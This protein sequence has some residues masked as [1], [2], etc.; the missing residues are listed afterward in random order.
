ML[1]YTLINE[2]GLG[3]RFSSLST[4]LQDILDS[5]QVYQSVS[6]ACQNHH[7]LD[8]EKVLMVEQLV[9]LVI[10]GFIHVEDLAREIDEALLFNNHKLS[11]SLA[12][13]ID[14]KVFKPIKAELEKNYRPLFQLS[15]KPEPT[16]LP[17]VPPKPVELEELGLDKMRAT[18]L[19][20]K[21]ELKIS[22][23]EA[24]GVP[25]QPKTMGEL[26]K[27]DLM[28]LRSDSLSA[29]EVATPIRPSQV[30]PPAKSAPAST[31]GTQ[32]PA[33][34]PFQSTAIV[35]EIKKLEKSGA[36]LVDVLKQKESRATTTQPP[37]L[38]PE[39]SPIFKPELK[40]TGMGPVMLHKELGPEPVI[41]APSFKLGRER[42][43]WDES[44][45]FSSTP[46]PPTARIET[47]ALKPTPQ[48]PTKT[49]VIKPPKVIHYSAFQ[50]PLER[51]ATPQVPPSILQKMP[52]PPITPFS[53]HLPT[54][55]Q[56]KPVA[57]PEPRVQNFL[58]ETAHLFE[59][60]RGII[61]EEKPKG[62]LSRLFVGKPKTNLNA[63][64]LE[65]KIPLPQPPTPVPQIKTPTPTV[66]GTNFM[67]PP[68]SNIQLP[69]TPLPPT[70][71][72]TDIKTSNGPKDKVGEEMIDLDAL[73][74]IGGP[75]Q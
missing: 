66:P 62:W 23:P 39:P 50:T 69:P 21:I 53:T 35:E 27:P 10:F 54:T 3:K 18:P 34:A 73:K 13:E 8:E 22:K 41:T 42:G 20:E 25:L 24:T 40:T 38:K 46:T 19:E 30:V 9:A 55:P 15:I 32:K 51:P 56:E 29:R 37:N 7:I 44:R 68:A 5:E 60:R 6:R 75:G 4:Q 33:T 61:P 58:G 65:P 72:A 47:G 1:D 31:P 48:A 52:T 26:E 2:I 64:G 70:P 16:T 63:A 45:P 74:K 67:K 28:S 11:R 59:E 12:D 14:A 17:T 57:K 49:E 71:A 36:E 43:Q